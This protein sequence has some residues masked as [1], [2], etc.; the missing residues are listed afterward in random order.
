ETGF[1]VPST[2]PASSS[3]DAAW[4][5]LGEGLLGLAT[6]QRTAIDLGVLVAR[7]DR[8]LA[9][10]ELRRRMGEAGRRRAR[11]RFDWAVVGRAPEEPWAEL[12]RAAGSAPSEPPAPDPLGAGLRTLFAAWPTRSLSP[13]AP[14]V[15]GPLADRAWP[16]RLL[17]D[18]AASLSIEQVLAIIEEIT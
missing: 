14:L 17:A 12:G 1:L 16:P 11:E 6:S 5:F 3:L 8:L 10:A 4:P 7:V 18:A 15:P 2:V 9:D 13:D